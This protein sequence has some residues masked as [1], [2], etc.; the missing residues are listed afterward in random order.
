MEIPGTVES[1]RAQ[2]QIQTP[3]IWFPHLSN[4]IIQ[5]QFLRR[6][7]RARKITTPTLDT[8]TVDHIPRATVVARPAQPRILDFKFQLHLCLSII[9]IR[10]RRFEL[11]DI[12]IEDGFVVDIRNRDGLRH[13]LRD[14]YRFPLSHR[15]IFQCCNDVHVLSE[16]LRNVIDGDVPQ[17]GATE[18]TDADA[19]INSVVAGC[20]GACQQPCP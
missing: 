19:A 11:R 16:R 14:G 13:V 15:H 4:V 18:T 2:N 17:R 1:F 9:R 3:S 12:V 5:S 20:A 10:N 6:S 8:R 7:L